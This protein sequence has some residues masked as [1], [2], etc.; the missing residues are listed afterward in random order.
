[1]A[2]F[3][4]PRSLLLVMDN[5]EHLLAAAASLADTLL[6]SAPQL[7][8]LTTSREPLRVAGEVV[9]RVP[10]LDIPGPEQGI[11]ARDLMSY[12]AVRLFVERAEAAAPGFSLDRANAV[13]VARIC[14]RLDGLPL[15]LELAAGRMGA[16]GPAA[17]S[18]RLDDRFRVLRSVSHAAPTRQHTLAATLQWS[19]D[20]LEADE[21]TLFRRLAVFTGGFDLEAV[22]DV[23]AG[24]PLDRAGIADLLARI[25]EKSI[26]TA[27]EDTSRERRYR[28][29]ETVRLYARERLDEAGES[30]ETAARHARWAIALAEVRRTSPRLDRDAANL[31]TALDTLLRR[32]PRDAL[33]LCT[34]LL[35]FWMRRIDLQEARRR[36]DE[37][38]AAAPERTPLAAQALLAAAAIDY[39]SGAL[40]RARARIEGSYAIA[41]ELGDAEAQWRALQLLGELGIAADTADAAEYWVERALDLARREGFAAAEA[42]CVYSLGVV[43]WIRGDLVTSEAFVAESLDLFGP[44]A[45][46]SERIPS[47]VNIAE[48]RMSQ[49]AGRTGLRVVF[50]DS[51]QPFS[52]ISCDAAITS[53]LASRAALVRTR[54]DFVRART[55]LDETFAR[56]IELGDESG[57]ASVLIRLA[58]LELAEGC[59]EAARRALAQALELRRAQI[60]RRGVGLVLAGL[61]LIETTVGDYRSAERHL[62][63]AHDIFRRA[64]D[65][66][67]LAS[68]LWRTADLAIA[69]GRLEHAEA[70][71]LEARAILKDTGRHRWVANTLA[72]LAEVAVLRGDVSRAVELLIEARDGYASRDDALGVEDIEESLR[73]FAGRTLS[74]AQPC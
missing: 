42:V 20:L 37:A 48:I 50:E 60:D 11:D 66:W 38:L 29:L 61:G 41:C 33:H 58:Y 35:P 56:T 49:P 57:R 27:D 45:G 52:E 28:L 21:R 9:F 51:L 40:R 2:E 1:V 22:E 23:C 24:G 71:L 44:L 25:V 46:S 31:R 18:E 34:V 30:D 12:E 64:G 26:V 15:A 5:C 10:S 4:A 67:G 8:I 62:A 68:T 65:R 55:L 72:G 16:L 14:L 7:T 6:R 13:D 19:H 17:I 74:S 53:V 43:H 63:E 69:R 73:A 36:F 54:G 59:P 3:L 32:A 70:A 39:R 47:P